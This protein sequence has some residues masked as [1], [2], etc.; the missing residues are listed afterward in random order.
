MSAMNEIDQSRC[1]RLA[2]GVRLQNDRL[3]DQPVLV[4]PEGV[5]FINPT[6]HD[7]LKQCDG[8]AT[9]NDIITSLAEE[10]DAPAEELGKDVLDCLVHLQQRKLLEF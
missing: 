3:T 10:Y 7:I 1:P 8:S 9:V 4:F 5:L 6:A 2:P